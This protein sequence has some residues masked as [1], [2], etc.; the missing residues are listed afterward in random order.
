M[1][2]LS[3]AFA[4]AGLIAAA[5]GQPPTGTTTSPAP[6]AAASATAAVTR[7]GTAIV[8]I[9]QCP[10]T[11]AAHYANQTVTDIVNNAVIEG[12]A[13]TNN[14]GDYVPTLAKSVPTVAN[15]GAKVSA[16]GKKL[17][18]TW[19]L[20]PSIKWS[21]GTPVTSED[22]KYTWEIWMKDPKVN[23][24]TGL[25]EIESTELPNQLAAV[26]HYTSIYASYP[27]NV[28]SLMPRALLEKEAD[29]S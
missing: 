14:N 8:A 5:C 2:R 10:S 27:L 17:D 18:V 20:K 3:I 12:L 11:L 13:E 29:I 22:I 7:G 16:D 26:V 1:R 6:S 15:G 24:R 25:R 19:E 9:W 4:V 28:I 21:D 23:D